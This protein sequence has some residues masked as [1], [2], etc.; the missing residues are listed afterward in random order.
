MASAIEVSVEGVSRDEMCLVVSKLNQITRDSTLD[1]AIRVGSLIVHYFYAGD[2]AL[3]RSRGPKTNS[4]RRLASHPQL[5]MSASVLYRCVAVFEICER[6]NVV[7]RWKSMTASHL[8][9]VLRL[10]EE[11]QCR[12]L[13]AA[14]RERW[15]VQRLEAESRD[16]TPAR[17]AGRRVKPRV[18]AYASALERLIQSAEVA[19]SE[20]DHQLSEEE[21]KYVAETLERSIRALSHVR[22]VLARYRVDE[23]STPPPALEACAGPPGRLSSTLTAGG[24]RT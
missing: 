9:V 2:M 21:H 12:L 5:P 3:W 13:A 15:S 7:T 19:D 24:R 4:F 18:V 20:D 6:L 23:R 14:D 1:Y 16:L 8:R 17:L 22:E 10:S 11:D